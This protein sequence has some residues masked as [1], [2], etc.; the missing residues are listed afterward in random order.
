[1]PSIDS[2]SSRLITTS[3]EGST[4]SG[5]EINATISRPFDTSPS[6]ATSTPTSAFSPATSSLA[7]TSTPSSFRPAM[8]TSAP[9]A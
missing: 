5:A 3:E 6:A 7:G 4:I 8:A 1:M 9:S 2:S